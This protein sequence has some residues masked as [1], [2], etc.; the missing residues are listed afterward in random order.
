MLKKHTKVQDGYKIQV[1]KQEVL[2]V[3]W[4]LSI[5]PLPRREDGVWVAVS[6]PLLLPLLLTV[7]GQRLLYTLVTLKHVPPRPQDLLLHSPV[8]L[9]VGQNLVQTRLT[10]HRRAG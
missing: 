10:L 4:C 6:L 7:G 5:S 3:R 9:H 8:A 2:W 1:S